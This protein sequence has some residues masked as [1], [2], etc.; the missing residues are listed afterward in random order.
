MGSLTL[1]GWGALISV[2]SLENV[3]QCKQQQQRFRLRQEVVL[4]SFS[5][6]Q[7]IKTIMFEGDSLFS[8]ALSSLIS[9][10]LII[11]RDHEE[12]ILLCISICPDTPFPEEKT[13][14]ME[15]KVCH[16]HS[17]R[18]AT[19]TAMKAFT[20]VVF[21][22]YWCV[23]LKCRYAFSINKALDL[24]YLVIWVNKCGGTEQT[25]SLKLDISV[26]MERISC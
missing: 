9:M 8:S 26:E 13:K 22:K 1:V 16:E 10:V 3:H 23:I 15:A 18:S 14:N 12:V 5:C 24:H 20:P 19:I 6:H 17:S 4:F 21:Q 11:Q 7:Y 2:N 25:Q